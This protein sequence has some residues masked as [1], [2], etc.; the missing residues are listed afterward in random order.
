M[1][2]VPPGRSTEYAPVK[3]CWL[4]GA[5][6]QMTEHAKQHQVVAI[7][8]E[9]QREEIAFAEFEAGQAI[10]RHMKAGHRKD[11]RQVHCGHLT[12]RNPARNGAAPRCGAGSQ[13]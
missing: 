1:A 9:V 10:V 3:S 4:V 2:I 13:I 12:I 5:I 7:F 8:L 11:F 6:K